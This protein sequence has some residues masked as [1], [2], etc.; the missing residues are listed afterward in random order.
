MSAKEEK[1][2]L[3]TISTKVGMAI[4]LVEILVLISYIT[5]VILSKWVIMAELWA[6]SRP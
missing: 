4:L 3:Y 1:I 6:L 2:L 5:V